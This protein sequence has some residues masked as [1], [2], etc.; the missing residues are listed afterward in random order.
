MTRSYTVAGIWDKRLVT[1]RPNHLAK[2]RGNRIEGIFDNN[3]VLSYSSPYCPG[4]CNV[5]RQILVAMP[6]F[7]A[8]IMP[9][10]AG[11]YIRNRSAQVLLYYPALLRNKRVSSV[12]LTL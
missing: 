3:Y 6:F 11:L 5:N 4:H 10:L 2:V 9:K 12:I 7:F 8:W 1:D